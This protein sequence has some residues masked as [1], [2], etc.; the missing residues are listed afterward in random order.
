MPNSAV[1]AVEWSDRMVA[2]MVCDPGVA[3]LADSLTVTE[4][5]PGEAPEAVVVQVVPAGKVRSVPVAENVTREP[6]TGFVPE[7]STVAVAVVD[8]PRTTV[9][10]KVTVTEPG[11]NWVRTAAAPCVPEVAE[12]FCVPA[13]EPATIVTEHVPSPAPLLAVVQLLLGEKVASP[14]AP[15]LTEAPPTRLPLESRAVAVACP[16]VAPSA[17][18][19]V[20]VRATDRVATGPGTRFREV[21]ALVPDST[22]LA[23]AVMF[24]VP[25]VVPALTV[26]V[27]V[28]EADVLHGLPVKVT[29]PDGE[30]VSVTVSLGRGADVT[31][32][33]TLIVA[34]DVEVPSAVMVPG[35]TPTFTVAL[36]GPAAWAAG[37]SAVAPTPTPKRAATEAATTR[38]PTRVAKPTRR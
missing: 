37:A 27:H 20:G 6:P 28:P 18:S 36:P 2:V 25:E 17:G 38:P 15:K 16:W 31:L 26:T 30:A 35:F 11:V 29:R 4:Q 8:P 21:G 5:V 34:V 13:S 9:G 23:D 33:I 24:T 10:A 1:L 3:T 19:A 7:S 22:P 32:S 14:L 12:M